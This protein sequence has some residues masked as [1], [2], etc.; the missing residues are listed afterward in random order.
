MILN[1]GR[2]DR[3]VC[4]EPTSCVGIGLGH[5]KSKHY[6]VKI[7]WIDSQ[8]RADRS[9][10]NRHH[11]WELGWAIQNQKPGPIGCVEYTAHLQL[12]MV[13]HIVLQ[14][15]LLGCVEAT[16]CVGIRLDHPNS[17]NYIGRNGCWSDSQDS[18]YG[19]TM[20]FD[21]SIH[22]LQIGVADV[23]TSKCFYI[24]GHTY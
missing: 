2:P 6:I 5:P 24:L 19:A 20:T 21:M 23:Y 11:V 13:M 16:S 15:G 17:W 8:D 1:T 4:V 3:S 9:A 14:Q 22:N 18:I 10:L 7:G 12:K